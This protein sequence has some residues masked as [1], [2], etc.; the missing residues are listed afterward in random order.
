MLISKI[1]LAIIC[2]PFANHWRLFGNDRAEW[3]G[4]MV[5][6]NLKKMYNVRKNDSLTSSIDLLKFGLSYKVMVGQ[7]HGRQNII[8][9]I[10]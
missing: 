10:A 3:A 4:Y 5:H 9:S 8:I 6:L 7:V 2:Y 1:D